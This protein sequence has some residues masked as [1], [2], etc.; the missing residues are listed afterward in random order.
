MASP[1]LP[2]TWFRLI[3]GLLVA[4]LLAAGAAEAQWGGGW[5]RW[6]GGPPRF[7]SEVA[8]DRSFVFARVMFESVRREP[9]GYG[10]STDYPDAD[11]N[12]M[13]RLSELTK[14]P[15]SFGQYREP[16]HVVVRLTDPEIFDYPFIFMSDVGTAFLS[17]DEAVGLRRYLEQGGFLWVDAFW[18]PAA[19]DV[20]RGEIHKALPFSQYPIVDLPLSHPI[21][22]GMFD[23]EGYPQIPSIQHWRRSGGSTTSERGRRSEQPH[24]RGITDERGRLMVLMTHNTD[25]AD[26]WEREGEDTEYFLAYSIDAYSIGINVLMYAMTH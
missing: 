15:V 2:R 18:G 16:N 12:F 11:Y 9:G 8:T 3:C 14:T 26:G 21:F 24:Y 23:M 20:W 22:R 25:V 19:W 5:R 10:W 6:R 13:I 1:V 4:V 17:D 7:P